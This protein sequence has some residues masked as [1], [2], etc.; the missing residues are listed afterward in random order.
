LPKLIAPNDIT[1]VILT[2]DEAIHIER[3]IASVSAIATRVLVVDS[4][5][6]DDTVDR[7]RALH[8]DVVQHVFVNQARQLQW[9]LESCDIDTAWVLRLDADEVIEPDLARAIADTLPSLPADVTGIN[10]KR[11]HIFMGRWIRHGGR[12]PLIMLRLWRNGLG[13]VEDR[14]MDEHV[15]V[16]S[17][18][19][20]TLDGGFADI[21]LRD[22]AWFTD[23]HNRYATREAVERV[24][25]RNALLGKDPEL[26]HQ[27]A[28]RQAATKRWIKER[29]YNKL[30]FGAGPFGYF[31]YRYLVQLGFL[32][33]RAGLIYHFLQGCWYRF[34]VEG[35]VVELEAGISNCV[36]PDA[37]RAQLADL[38]GL[39]I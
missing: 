27:S 11:R 35:R 39:R 20:I 24:G 33:G 2:F 37:R 25:R 36:T 9:A 18:R 7:A 6:R 1:V 31:L 10:F 30:P 16:T 19:T 22:L 8:A 14:W 21:N 32:D 28:S 38:T 26:D 29:F 23:K 13:R 4:F 5:S 34:L 15:A 12:Y 17:G 3:A